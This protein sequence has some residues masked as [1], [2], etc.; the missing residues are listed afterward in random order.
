MSEQDRFTTAVHK[1]L[2]HYVSARKIEALRLE[3]IRASII[4]RDGQVPY[5]AGPPISPLHS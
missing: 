1:A 5:E 2:G 3:L 4:A